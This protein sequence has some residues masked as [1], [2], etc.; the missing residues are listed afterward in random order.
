MLDQQNLFFLFLSSW[1]YEQERKVNNWFC[2]SYKWFLLWANLSLP[3]LLLSFNPQSLFIPYSASLFSTQRLP[4]IFIQQMLHI[5]AAFLP[6]FTDSLKARVHVQAFISFCFLWI[7]FFFPCSN[8]VICSCCMGAQWPDDLVFVELTQH[9][10]WQNVCELLERNP[11]AS[12]V[13]ITAFV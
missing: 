3:V 10:Y 5:I 7:D 2:F 1:N 12:R 13:F 6:S 4:P 11:P 8:A 9:R